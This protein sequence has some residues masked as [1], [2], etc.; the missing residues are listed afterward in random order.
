MT[1]CIG[2]LCHNKRRI[3]SVS[4]TKVSF[5]DF[6]ADDLVVKSESLLR[7]GGFYFPETI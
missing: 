7:T 3:V 2:A 4:D 1:V 6:S 5:G